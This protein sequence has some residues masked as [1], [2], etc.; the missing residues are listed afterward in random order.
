MNTS[1]RQNQCSVSPDVLLGTSSTRWATNLTPMIDRIHD[2]SAADCRVILAG[3]APIQIPLNEKSRGFGC[4]EL[5]DDMTSP[6]P[7]IKG[8]KSAG[9]IQESARSA[10]HVV[11]SRTAIREIRPLNCGREI[12]RIVFAIAF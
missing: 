10:L 4:C 12:R 1:A 9:E 6:F 3:I 5:R 2:R 7:G 8:P 11:H